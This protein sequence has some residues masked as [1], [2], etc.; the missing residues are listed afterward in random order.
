MVRKSVLSVVEM[1]NEEIIKEHFRPR[2]EAKLTIPLKKGDIVIGKKDSPAKSLFY[3][4]VVSLLENGFVRVRRTKKD[5][6]GSWVDTVKEDWLENHSHFYVACP[7][8]IGTEELLELMQK[9]RAV[10]HGEGMK[11]GIELRIENFINVLRN[12][13]Q[14]CK[15]KID[16][17]K[18][19]RIA[20]RK[21]FRITLYEERARFIKRMIRVLSAGKGSHKVLKN[22]DQKEASP[23]V[24]IDFLSKDLVKLIDADKIGYLEVSSMTRDN[25]IEL[26]K[27]AYK[28]EELITVRIPEKP[29]PRHTWKPPLIVNWKND[30]KEFKKDR[31]EKND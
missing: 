30:K 3:G 18:K 27:R 10:G 31:S 9:S 11:E 6:K 16:K 26:I 24:D 21:P 13:L 22:L 28:K 14:N 8:C 4:E 23:K 15:I 1:N 19:K 2:I 29:A 20:N 25:F 7:S 17:V 5:G 12:E